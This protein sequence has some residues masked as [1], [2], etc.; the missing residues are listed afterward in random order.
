[1]KIIEGQLRCKELR[2][3]LESLKV[4][5][6][7]WLSEDA[8]GIVAKIEY[9]PQTNQMVGLVLPIDSSTGL[10]IPFTYMSRN[11]TEIQRNMNQ[12]NQHL[13]MW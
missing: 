3:Y 4:E 1:M 2:N 8:S 6:C 7:V 9:D 12:N 13:Y 5:K 11:D 10:P